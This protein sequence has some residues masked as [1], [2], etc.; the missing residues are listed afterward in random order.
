ML[1]MTAIYV[2]NIILLLSSYML[3]DF[4]QKGTANQYQPHFLCDNRKVDDSL[5]AAVAATK[6][7]AVENHHRSASYDFAARLRNVFVKSLVEPT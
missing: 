2:K 3:Y 6:E 1:A 4:E 7:E 5:P